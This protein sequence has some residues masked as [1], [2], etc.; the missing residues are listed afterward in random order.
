MLNVNKSQ[1]CYWLTKIFYKI[2]DKI[3]RLFYLSYFIR[4]FLQIS[5]FILISS[6]YEVQDCNT[7]D[8][9]R[10]ISFAFSIL[11]ILTFVLVVWLILYLIFSS[12]EIVRKSHN[13]LEEFFRGVQHT[14]KHR[15]YII[16]LLLRRITFI[17][18]LVIITWIHSRVLVIFLSIIQTIYTIQL[19]YVRPFQETKE[20]FIEILNEVYFSFL[21]IFLA[22][23]NTEDEWNSVKTSIY[24]WVLVSNTLVTFLITSC[25]VY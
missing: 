10:L 13:K 12:Y 16:L 6:I 7:S 1:R 8:S 15:F 21:I 9:Y 4:N 5:Q 2:I 20:N 24:M 17:A 22:F 18:L 14:K 11:M 23:T 25:K 3:Y 19:S